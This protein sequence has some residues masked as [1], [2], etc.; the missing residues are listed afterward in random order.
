[1]GGQFPGSAAMLVVLI[2]FN[3]SFVV[4]GRK[5]IRRAMEH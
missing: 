3:L 4:A 2:L 1:V 5:W